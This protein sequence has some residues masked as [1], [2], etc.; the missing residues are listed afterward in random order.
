LG[1]VLTYGL[2]HSTNGQPIAP[3]QLRGLLDGT[4]TVLGDGE[5]IRLALQQALHATFLVML[6][7]AVLIVPV[8]LFIPRPQ[9]VEAAQEA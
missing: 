9:P 8:C 1:A 4:A 5:A 3:E 7:I 6:V 2:A